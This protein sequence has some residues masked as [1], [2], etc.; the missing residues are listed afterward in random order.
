MTPATN[1]PAPARPWALRLA[2]D[3]GLVAV[4]S[5]LFAVG[6]NCFMEPNGL[7]PGGV[8]GLAITI[9]AA[10]LAAGGPDLPVGVQTLV[11]NTLLMVLAWRVGGPRY[12]LR[13]LAGI[14]LSALFID[15]LRPVLPVLGGGDLLLCSLWGGVVCGA[16]LGL[17][18]RTGSNTGG[19]DIICQI[20]ARHTSLP[21]GTW[22]ILTDL[23]VVALSAPV[24]SVENALYATVAMFLMGWVL[25]QVV[26]GLRAERV[27]WVI[28][29]EHESIARAILDELDRGCTELTARG[30]WTGE[31]RPVLFVILGR[32]DIAPLK[33]IVADLD[34]NAIVVISEVHEAF[35]EGF[36]KLE[37]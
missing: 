9:R 20:L 6:L 12:V 3:L 10:V 28:S 18:F 14:V 22:V 2:R 27:A 5:A 36:R 30:K 26:D 31:S 1:T 4:G 35:G 29:T 7:A 25:D 16:G 34:P 19:T 24:F 8:S 11:M 37:P 17:V 32:A 33:A 21:V 15:A 23:M 13:S